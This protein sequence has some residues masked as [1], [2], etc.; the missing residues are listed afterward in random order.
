[1]CRLG[2]PGPVEP[3]LR[4]LER[5]HLGLGVCEE[6]LL[7]CVGEF[8]R[9]FVGLGAIA[10]RPVVGG[11][12]V[13]RRGFCVVGSLPAR[14]AAYV[15]EE[16]RAIGIGLGPFAAD[17]RAPAKEVRSVI[18]CARTG[19]I[20]RG[21]A[22]DVLN[23]RMPTV[24]DKLNLGGMVQHDLPGVERRVLVRVQVHVVGVLLEHP[25]PFV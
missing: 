15:V 2:A 4:S 5:R 13:C 9:F 24:A 3:A 6:E 18:F 12:T 25:L 21:S 17:G 10:R 22:V 7:V 14:A 11:R 20:P 1:M 16:F 23:H 8:T 19:N